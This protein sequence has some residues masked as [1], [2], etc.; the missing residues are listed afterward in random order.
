MESRVAVEV[1]EVEARHRHGARECEGRKRVLRTMEYSRSKKRNG[2][3]NKDGR[4]EERR[5]LM[6]SQE[7]ERKTE[8]ELFGS[9]EALVA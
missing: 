8:R 6:V 7:E 2:E 3:D 9:D 4:D 5:A 1:G